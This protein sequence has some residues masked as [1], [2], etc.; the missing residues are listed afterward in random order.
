MEREERGKKDLSVCQTKETNK[1]K[2]E[3][4]LFIPF[5]CCGPCRPRLLC[6]Q[7]PGMSQEGWQALSGASASL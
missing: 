7:Y 5:P 3:L 2:P 1:Q 4:S 6:A